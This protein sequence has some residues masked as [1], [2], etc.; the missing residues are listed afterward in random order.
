MDNGSTAIGFIV[1]FFGGCIG[2]IL[3]YL[4]TKAPDTR[5]GAV[6]GFVVSIVLGVIFSVLVLAAGSAG[7]IAG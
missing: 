7:A 2:L 6:I 1:G 3:V 4:L 5:R